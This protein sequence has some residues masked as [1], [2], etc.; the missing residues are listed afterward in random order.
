[1]FLVSGWLRVKIE[2]CRRPI[3]GGA[4]SPT[5][6]FALSVAT[7]DYNSYPNANSATAMGFGDSRRTLWWLRQN[8]T[9]TALPAANKT[10][11]AN[12]RVIHV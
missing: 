8:I 7:V 3:S 1:M 2:E 6:A 4:F 5:F 11:F 10:L 12:M 9:W